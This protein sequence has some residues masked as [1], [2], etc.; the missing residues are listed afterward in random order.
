MFGKSHVP[1]TAEWLKDLKG[2]IYYWDP[3][4]SKGGYRNSVSRPRGRRIFMG[5][6]RHMTVCY[7]FECF[8]EQ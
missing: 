3:K 1:R 8:V 4:Q 6:E 5:N 7:C 2:F